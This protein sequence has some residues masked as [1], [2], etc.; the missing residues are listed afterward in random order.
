MLLFYVK[1]IRI[2]LGSIEQ[3]HPKESKREKDF[4]CFV[5]SR[6]CFFVAFP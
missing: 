3:A 1:N 4:A 2:D 6:F 5:S